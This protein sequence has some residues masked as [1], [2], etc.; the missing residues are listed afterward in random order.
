MFCSRVVGSVGNILYRAGKI[1]TVSTLFSQYQLKFSIPV[2]M[3]KF[4]PCRWTNSQLSSS[5]HGR[6]LLRRSQPQPVSRRT[7]PLLRSSQRSERSSRRKAKSL[8]AT[9]RRSRCYL[10]GDEIGESKGLGFGK[11][12]GKNLSWSL[13]LWP[14]PFSLNLQMQIISPQSAANKTTFKST[15]ISASSKFSDSPESETT[16]RLFSMFHSRYYPV[17]SALLDVLCNFK[18]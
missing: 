16:Q 17:L 8:L 9:R 5:L 11:K 2:G 18:L 10:W 7:Q 6:R 4:G 14:K 15:S 12:L 3:P 1:S 13:F